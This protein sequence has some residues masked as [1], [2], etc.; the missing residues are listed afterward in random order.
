MIRV[1]LSD[2]KKNRARLYSTTAP[3]EH[4]LYIAFYFFFP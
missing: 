2:L 4:E 1:T 3:K